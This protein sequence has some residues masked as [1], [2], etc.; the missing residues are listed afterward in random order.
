MG[1]IRVMAKLGFLGLG[2]MGAP[3]ARNLLQ[4][5]HQ[6]ALWSN[7]AAKAKQLAA[8]H[9]GLFCETPKA[10]A[11]NA[12]VIFLCV[13]DTAMSEKVILG[14]NGLSSGA[15]SGTVIADASTVNPSDSRRIAA[16]LSKSGISFLDA[17]CTGSKPG[18]EGGNL[19]FM[20]GGEQS[21]FDKVRPSFEPM[22]KKIYYCGGNGMG[23]HAKLTQNLILCNILQA[24][25]EGLVLSTK[26]GVPPEL[27]LDILA[28]SAAKSGLIEYKA[29]FVLRRDFSTN[30]STKWMHKDIG[31]MLESAA[32]LNVPVPLTALTR[33]L[34]QAAISVGLGESDMCSTIQ[35][36]ENFAQIKVA[37]S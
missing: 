31:L 19:T 15:K 28:N 11:E 37:K 18:A 10:V 9:K 16:E 5:G 35:I 23:L 32:E 26:A 22:G 6:V 25:N 24:F 20:V 33:Q 27:M 1:T 8:D 21:V 12:D 29:P 14:E 17:P 34:F 30:F 3:M 13:G 7:T 36:L 2:I 4:A